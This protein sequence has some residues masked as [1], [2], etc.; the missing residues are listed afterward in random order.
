MKKLFTLLVAAA[1]TWSAYSQIYVNENFDTGIPGTWNIIDG[2]AATGD[3]WAQGN[4]ASRWLD[5]TPY[6]TVDSDANGNGI[7]LIETLESPVFDASSAPN[8]FLEFDHWYNAIGSDSGTV[9][10]F[11]GTQWVV[12]ATFNMD[13]GA[14][15]NPDQQSIDISAYKNANMQVRFHYNDGDDWAWYWIVDNV[16]VRSISCPD[17]SNLAV[18]NLLSTSADL[19]WTENGTATTWNVE[20]GV[21]GFT[22]GTGTQVNGTSSNP[23][24][25]SGLTPNTAYQFYVQADCGGGNLSMYIGPFTFTTLCSS[26]S[27][28]YL[29]TVESHISTTN[30]SSSNCWTATQTGSY[31]WDITGTGTTPSSG[32]GATSAYSGTKYFFTE[33]SSGVSGDLASLYSPLIDISSLSNPN[34]YYYY[35]MFGSVIGT[36]RV[37]VNDGSGWTQV[38]ILSGAQQTA[39]TDP[40]AIR[41]ISLASFGNQVQVLFEATSAGTFAGDICIDDIS[42]S[43]LITCPAP[44]FLSVTNITATQA[45]LSWTEN[46]SATNWNIEYGPAG[47]TPGSGTVVAV[48][49]NPYTLTGLSPQ[50]NYDFYVQSDCGGGDL[51]FWT[52]PSS[53]LTLCGTASTPFVDNVE[54]HSATTNLTT[55]NCWTS[56]QTG[57]FSWDIT[58]SGTTPSFGTGAT[59]A[60]SGTK[61]FFTE[62]SSGT[63]GDVANLYSP[64]M[65]ITSLANPYL[66]YYYHMFG[67]DMGTLR[68][69]VDAGSG[70]VLVDSL[71]GAQQTAQTDP[72]MQRMVNLSSFSGTIQILFEAT[73]AGTFEGDICID[74]ISVENLITCLAPSMLGSFNETTTTADVFWTE[75]GSATQWMIE[76]GPSGFTPGS[77]TLLPASNDTVTISGLSPSSGYEFYV[78]ANCGG[79][80]LSS[81]VGPFA[82]NTACGVA[83]APWSDNFEAHTASTSWIISNCWAD[84]SNAAAFNW[85]IT[86]TGTT[87]ST[88]TGALSANSGTKYIFT[89]ASSGVTGAIA[90][91]LSPLVD[92]SGLTAPTLTFYYHMFGTAMGNLY[93]YVNGT[94]VDSIIGQQQ[95]AQTDSWMMRTIDLSSFSGQIQ[96]Q[97]LGERGTSFT[98]DICIDDVSIDNLVGLADAKAQSFN[99]YPNPTNDVVFIQF[100]KQIESGKIELLNVTGE[101]VQVS[102]INSSKQVKLDVSSLSEGMYFVR[103]SNAQ[104]TE[105][106]KLIIK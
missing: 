19:S 78:Q 71:S 43:D 72:F 91:L 74:D 46:G 82:F 57:S 55:S 92:I 3:S 32:T 63:I 20:Y 54:S 21:S 13:I 6:A 64:A 60:N 15:N 86:G 35:H 102:S 25:I 40:F 36:L 87:P 73:S 84:S 52:G 65:D 24:S 9:E 94:V 106:Q 27:S 100:A 67:G 23:L 53:F 75:N 11:D 48:S 38:D 81:W 95:T 98:S 66:Y 8:L 104:T 83:M 47:F 2:G 5:G 101:I 49:T 79:G 44:S 61:F 77:G 22:L 59:A 69:Y 33:A 12:V 45:D 34:L 39:Q 29:E 88:G 56:N 14:P 50:T 51:S 31:S 26:L 70:W 103:I 17:P 42:I 105:T 28:P 96:V 85:D 10:V 7:H 97:F 76:Y 41:Q 80:D 16:L 62:A 30:L 4:N 89:E 93:V 1:T 90:A 68:V 99:L 18:A 58:A 37:Y